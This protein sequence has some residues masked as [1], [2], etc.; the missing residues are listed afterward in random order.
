LTSRWTKLAPRDPDLWINHGILAQH[1]GQNDEA[2]SAWEHAL[3]LDPKQQNA[4]LYLDDLADKAHHP[5]EAIPHYTTYLQS[6]S[7]HPPVPPAQSVVPIMLRLAQCLAD[8]GQVDAAVRPAHTARMIA[9]RAHDPR[10]ESIASS[11]EAEVRLRQGALAEATE[12]YQHALQLDSTLN[13]RQLAAFDW[14]NYSVLLRRRGLMRQ[15][16]ASLL[17]A[18][19]YSESGSPEMSEIDSGL[20]DLASRSPREVAGVNAHLV[21]EINAAMS[22]K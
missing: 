9:T 19:Q 3:L 18:R 10:L 12:L 14:I 17:K 1:A 6:I 8:T 7:D 2:R 22:V 21:T 11:A 16:Y 13:D 20:A 4:H 15:S 5:A